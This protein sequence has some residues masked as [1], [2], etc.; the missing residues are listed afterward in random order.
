[1]RPL[2]KKKMQIQARVVD[3]GWTSICDVCGCRHGTG[4][5]G[6]RTL[7]F[8]RCEKHANAIVGYYHGVVSQART[9]NLRRRKSR[10]K[11]MAD[12]SSQA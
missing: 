2:N 1:M 7:D 12:A 3:T 10:A 6:P 4:P 9:E 11:S 5:T 8:V